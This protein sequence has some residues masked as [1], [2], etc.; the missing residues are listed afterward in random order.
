MKRHTSFLLS[1]VLFT[2][3]LHAQSMVEPGGKELNTAY[4]KPRNIFQK[5]TWLD[6]D[7]RVVGL[8]TLNCITRID[9]VKGKLMYFQIRN[10]GKK[11]STI[12]EWPT[13]APIYTSETSSAG[14]IVFDHHQKDSVAYFDDFLSDYLIGALPLKPGYK[15]RFIVCGDHKSVVTIKDVFT[16]VLPSG[17]AQPIQVWLVQANFAGFDVL[18]WI[19]KTSGDM[20]KSLFQFQDGSMF[21]KSKI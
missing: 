1:F 18:Y 2:V 8:A 5:L 3:A 19:D 10:D 15:G 4:F 13:L 7:G 12:A 11:D 16:D 9:T 14:K 21:M 6:K 20:L 17:N